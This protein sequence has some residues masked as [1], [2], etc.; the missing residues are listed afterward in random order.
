MDKSQLK[1]LLC[2]QIESRSA[3]IIASGEKL[4]R[5]PELSYKEVKS[6]AFAAE[7]LASC[8]LEVKRGIA[9][10]GLRADLDTGRPGPRV[11][12]LGGA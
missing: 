1:E 10:T 2:R 7:F 8:G 3:D 9:V 6:S 11:G 12:V 4:L 5:M